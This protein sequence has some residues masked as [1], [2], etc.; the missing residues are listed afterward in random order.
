[1]RQL[2]VPVRWAA[3]VA[4]TA[5]ASAGCMSVG[6][7]G[8]KP[9]R[10]PTAEPRGSAAVPDGGTVSGTGTVRSGGGRA[11]AH[12][13]R[14]AAESPDPGESKASSV[15]SEAHPRTEHGEA[16]EPAEPGVP[17]PGHGGGRPEPSAVEPGPGTP[18][19][20]ES[21]SPSEPPAPEPPASPDPEG[22]AGPSPQPSASPAAEFR[23]YAMSLPGG[24]AALR[25]PEASPQ[26]EPA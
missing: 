23:A 10:T 9:P 12:S 1:M 26:V 8:D 7:D 4:V 20:P 16:G 19:R 21:P 15:P 25:T 2:S 18:Q 14:E 11:E 24:P 3:V 5:A 17:G 6:D 13:E 22:P